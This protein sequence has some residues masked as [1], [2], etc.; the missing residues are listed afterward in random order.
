MDATGEEWYY[1]DMTDLPAIP[2]FALFGETDHFPDVLHC[3]RISARA[4]AHGWTISAHRHG[5]MAQLF[6][7]ENGSVRAIVDGTQYAIESESFLYIPAQSV[8]EFIFQPDTKGKVIFFPQSILRTIGPTSPELSASLTRHFA[9]IRAPQLATLTDALAQLLQMALPYRHQTAL[10]L[11]HSMLSVV[12]GLAPPPQTLALHPTRERL[13]ELDALIVEHQSDGW[14]AAEYAAALAVSTG[15]L[16]RLCR[17]A[18]G[19]GASIYIERTLMEEACR[20]LAFTRMS[21]A[22]AGYRLGYADPSYFSKRFRLV[23]GQSP[24]DYRQKFAT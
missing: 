11:A 7:I 13:R 10:G 3:E 18:T 12:A 19:A 20:L 2:V 16:S 17:T 9:G 23:Q 21:V 6:E 24:T 1:S 4:P 15:H 8:H 22:E 14:G 5:Q